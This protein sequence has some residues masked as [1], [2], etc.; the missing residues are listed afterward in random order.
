[1][2]PVDQWSELRTHVLTERVPCV[3]RLSRADVA[4][5]RVEHRNHL[6]V[7]PVNG[8]GRYQLTSRGRVG[9]IVGPNTRLVIRPKIPPANLF[10][11]LDPTAPLP[12]AEDHATTMPGADALDFLAGRLSHL[13]RE[14]VAAGLHRS[15]VERS[16]QGP[17]LQGR[18]DVPAQLRGAT[19]RKDQ[20]HS[21]FEEYT[22]DIPCNQIPK[23]TTERIL[24]SPL[25]GESVRRILQ[26]MLSAFATVS[27]VPLE[28][29]R[30]AAA[31]LDR[32]TENYRP[33][34]D[35]CRLLAELL[36]PGDAAGSTP[37]PAFLLDMERVFERYLTSCAEQYFD[38]AEGANRYRVQVQP[39]IQASQPQSDQPALVV[40]P[41][42]ILDRDNHPEVVIDA[43]WK[44]LSSPLVRS[45]VYQMLAYCTILGGNRAVLI[46]P[47]RRNRSWRYRLAESPIQ[48]QVRKLRVTGTRESLS[49][50]TRRLFQSLL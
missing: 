22:A 13:L 48:L 30:F 43:K 29:D 17:F 14:R 7:V 25:L 34:L 16:Q 11:L 19:G 27:A 18:I 9:T 42:L 20:L 6:G 28:L 23:A 45:D 24:R 1:M 31:G 33:L 47:G 10:Y 44:A 3:C 38:N 4:F 5:L 8:R 12:L 26:P 46:Y 15:Y 21:C 39:L 49:K 35:L 50:S 37:Y 36:A 41:D 40:R 32:L 2:N